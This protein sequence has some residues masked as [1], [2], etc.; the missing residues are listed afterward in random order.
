MSLRALVMQLGQRELDW[1]GRNLLAPVVAPGRATVRLNGLIYTFNI[2]PAEQRGFGVF[3]LA[4][5]GFADWVRD[6]TVQ[7]R[8]KYLR[9]WPHV[10]L[11]LLRELEP[12]NWLAYPVS[13]QRA[14]G[15]L[16]LVVH[17]VARGSQFELIRAAFDG[18]QLWYFDAVG[19]TRLQLAEEMSRALRDYVT[20]QELRLR[21][22]TPEDRKAYAWLYRPPRVAAPTPGDPDETRLRLALARGGG[23]LHG[24]TQDSEN[25]QV[26]WRD[27]HGDMQF[28]C[29]RRRDLTVVSA[30]ICLSD[31]DTDF[32]LTSL[33]GVVEEDR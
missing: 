33:V 18:R 22:L 30:G 31:R 21:G 12:G 9:L 17:E 26:S 6:A 32:D 15:G 25:Y 3:R 19:N 10:R 7:E 28:S 2:R 8:E 16:P 5:E 1:Q 14:T 29:V 24:F 13:P 27:S 20:P 23:V 4:R 11:R